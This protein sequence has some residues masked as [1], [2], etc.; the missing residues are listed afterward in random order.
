MDD[1]DGEESES[2]EKKDAITMEIGMKT[3]DVRVEYM[4]PS[5][6]LPCLGLRLRLLVLI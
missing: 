1:G 5:V 4:C 6:Y 3:V 2:V